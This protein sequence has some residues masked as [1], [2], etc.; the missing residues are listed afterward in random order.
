[1]HHV[2]RAASVIAIAFGLA[3]SALGGL[4]IDF[5]ASRHTK[6]GEHSTWVASGDFNEDGHLDVAVSNDTASTLSILLGNGRGEFAPAVNIPG[7]NRP[8][9]IVAADF[10]LD[11]HLDLATAEQFGHSIFVTPGNGA[12]SFGPGRSFPMGDFTDRLVAGDFNEDGRPDVAANSRD[13][14]RVVTLLGDGAGGLGPYFVSA[15]NL[16][17]TSI[18]TADLNRDGHLD[19]VVGRRDGNLV[20]IL[21]GGGQGAFPTQTAYSAIVDPFSVAAADFNGDGALDVVVGGGLSPS[22]AVLLSN[23][24]GGFGSARVL[25]GSPLWTVRTTDMDVDGNPDIVATNRNLNQVSVLRGDGAGDFEAPRTFGVG[26]WPCDLATGDFDEDGR[27]DVATA[28]WSGYDV[29]LLLGDGR[30]N[31]PGVLRQALPLEPRDIIA[32]DFNEDG[33]EDVALAQSDVAIRLGDGAGGFGPPQTY[34]AD[35]QV[36]SL[37]AGDFNG[38]G[39]LDLATGNQRYIIFDFPPP[40]SISILLGD[41]QGGF[42]RTFG[43]TIPFYWWPPVLVPGDFN[44]DGRLDLAASNA[45]S[46][47]GI[48]VFLGD[49]DGSLVAGPRLNVSGDGLGMVAADF[50]EDGH[51]DLAATGGSTSLDL[52]LGDGAGGFTPYSWLAT[53]RIPQGVAAVD[54]NHDGHVDFAVANHGDGLAIGHTVSLF[55]GTGTGFFQSAG[56]LEVDT[57]PFAVEGADFNADGH[58]DLA[59]ANQFGVILLPGRGDGTFSPGRTFEA[60]TSNTLVVADFDDNGSPDLACGGGLSM[61]V[62]LNR[63]PQVVLAV[64][65]GGVSWSRVGTATGYDLVRGD[66]SG[67]LASGG[68]FAVSTLECLGNDLAESALLDPATPPAGSGF[69]Y[70]ARAVMPVGRGTYDSGSESQVGSRDAEIDASAL[71]CP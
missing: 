66:L 62:M 10:N 22:L 40:P 64:E 70:L 27:L 5:Q 57:L 36:F 34:R 28:N 37:A 32:G 56:L 54:L 3:S 6:A 29:S 24:T 31:L 58:A 26:V 61:T 60:A 19:L 7:G 33:W 68:D 44:E 65:N 55:L 8:A 49:G 67:L 48:L 18:T 41:G 43:T 15:S 23:G 11:G 17:S 2:K 39:H 35:D 51:L 59:V 21:Y 71:S 38:D 69:W 25:P 53:Q 13:L 12:G 46:D 20:S 47:W 50:D 30:G 45:G 16:S 4:P 42:T 14:R 63:T 52:L 1:M 9:A